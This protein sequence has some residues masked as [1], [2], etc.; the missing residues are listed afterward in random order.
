M[1]NPTSP[2]PPDWSSH[3]SLAFVEVCT[4]KSFAKYAFPSVSSNDNLSSP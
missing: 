1:Q 3:V 2:G 4:S